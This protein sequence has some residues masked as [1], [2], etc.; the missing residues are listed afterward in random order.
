[1]TCM[2]GPGAILERRSWNSSGVPGRL[3]GNG[4]E[5]HLAENGGVAGVVDLE[6][7]LELQDVP[8]GLAGVDDGPVLFGD[9]RGVDGVG[10]GDLDPADLGGAA[11]LHR[12]HVLDTLAHQVGG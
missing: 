1:M 2:T 3:T 9:A 8:A 4:D 10:R 12:H 11:L 7:A 6:A 5:L